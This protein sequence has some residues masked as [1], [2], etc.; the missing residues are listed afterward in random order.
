M[1]NI[2][3]LSNSIAKEWLKS[4]PKKRGNAKEEENSKCWIDFLLLWI[5]ELRPHWKNK[6][7]IETYKK[8]QRTKQ[9][10]NYVL[11]LFRFTSTRKK[12]K[13]KTKTNMNDWARLRVYV[14]KFCVW[15]KYFP[16][17]SSWV[18]KF[19]YN[20]AS[21][22]HENE[23]KKPHTPGHV[24]PPI[25]YQ[26]SKTI[27]IDM[28]SYN[29]SVCVWQGKWLHLFT[30]NSTSTHAQVT[31]PTKLWRIYIYIFLCKK[32]SKCIGF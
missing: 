1:I 16:S 28:V 6:K 12:Q 20:F 32:K 4:S 3:C 2:E 23:K 8:T 29:R 7:L 22:S 26:E 25:K 10:Y 19:K 17:S 18:N 9:D 27:V 24:N 11:N 14:K 30:C 21:S 5:Q 31:P 15:I 13:T